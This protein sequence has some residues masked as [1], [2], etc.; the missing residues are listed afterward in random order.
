[1]KPKLHTR[2]ACCVVSKVLYIQ[3][4]IKAYMPIN[5]NEFML[6]FGG[7][8][9]EQI[10]SSNRFKACHTKITCKLFKNY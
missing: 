1:M 5:Q 10:R 6:F 8:K 3:K 2:A 9:M 4:L 7:E